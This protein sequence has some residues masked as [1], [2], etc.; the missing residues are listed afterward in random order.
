MLSDFCFQ[1][2]LTD[3]NLREGLDNYIVTKMFLVNEE[4]EKAHRNAIVL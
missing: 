3:S 4:L 1:A 2:K